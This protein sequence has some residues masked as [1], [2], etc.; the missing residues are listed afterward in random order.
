MARGSKP[1]RNAT[2]TAIMTPNTSAESAF[3]KSAE[4]PRSMAR[5]M[6]KIGVIRGETSMAPIITAVLLA[7][8]PM[9]AIR[10][11]TR[12]MA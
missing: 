10:D 9:L 11:E 2:P 4:S 12:S 1:M 6:P 3:Q 5:V 7:I 8:K